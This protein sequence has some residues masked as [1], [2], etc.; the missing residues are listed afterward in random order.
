MKKNAGKKLNFG[1]K[2]LNFMNC[3]GDYFSQ[4]FLESDN[5]DSAIRIKLF[6][7]QLIDQAINSIQLKPTFKLFHFTFEVLFFKK[8]QEVG[9]N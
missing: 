9:Q 5:S 7:F 6:L 8:E 4:L 1:K 3:F 2:N